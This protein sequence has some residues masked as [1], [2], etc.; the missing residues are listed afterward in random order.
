VPVRFKKIF[1]NA[2]AQL[3]LM[4]AQS[5]EEVMSEFCEPPTH[6]GRSQFV[7]VCAF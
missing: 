5:Y 1:W 6:E 3:D 2:Q 7:Y 4:E